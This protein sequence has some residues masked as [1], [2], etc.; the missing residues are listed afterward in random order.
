MSYQ[1]CSAAES[2]AC[3]L[4]A[5]L[6]SRLAEA[7]AATLLRALQEAAAEEEKAG[8]GA[9]G[10]GLQSTSLK[11]DRARMDV[12]T[13]VRNARP[14]AIAPL[15]AKRAE[16][17]AAHAQ[18]LGRTAAAW[19][20]VAGKQ[21]SR[22]ATK[23]ELEH[24]AREIPSSA[25]D[26]AVLD[27]GAVAA[28]ADAAAEAVR[29]AAR[30]LL[31]AR[32]A[33]QARASLL[34]EAIRAERT[35]AAALADS[36]P[37]QLAAARRVVAAAAVAAAAETPAQDAVRS[38][39]RRAEVEAARADLL[40]A[41]VAAAAAA[42]A[43]ERAKPAAAALEQAGDDLV[44]LES[45]KKKLVMRKGWTAEKER[46]HMAKRA[47]LEATVREKQ[48]AVDAAERLLRSPL[49]LDCFPE[50]M[51]GFENPQA[52]CGIPCMPRTLHLLSQAPLSPAH[53]CFYLSIPE[54]MFRPLSGG[55]TLP[56]L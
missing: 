10:G 52:G 8:V 51:A 33:T 29:R 3:T 49:A 23:A 19:A 44:D 54:V 43:A 37:A 9:G 5:L 39:R 17:E 18:Q 7:D 1:A 31:P 14:N 20:G 6:Q 50:L 46:R 36:L 47:E 21:R 16:A 34:L 45:H 4:P 2:L 24:L 27:Q 32:E 11:L 13:A 55:A 22:A 38:E 42:A 48:A 40:A 15:V 28:A 25:V 12:R 26:A 53:I 30:E 41:Q 35:A 56:V